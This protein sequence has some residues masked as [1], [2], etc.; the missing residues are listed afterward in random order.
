M[1]ALESLEATNIGV[2][3]SGGDFNL[4][5]SVSVLSTP[6]GSTSLVGRA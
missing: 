1:G 5:G 4:S 6:R 3:Q 2:F